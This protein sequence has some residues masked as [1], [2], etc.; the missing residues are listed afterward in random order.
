METALF[1]NS[2]KSQ[3]CPPKDNLPSLDEFQSGLG[4]WAIV[5]YSCSGLV[6]LALALQYFF[7][8]KQF[9]QRLQSEQLEHTLWVSSVFLVLSSFNLVG[10]VLPLASEFIWLAYK[11]GQKIAEA[12]P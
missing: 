3:T 9:L 7:L 8:V 1:N 11:V 10:V 6:W 4:A 12:F 2:F 5:L